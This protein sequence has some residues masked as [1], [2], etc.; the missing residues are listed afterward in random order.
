MNEKKEKEEL[1]KRLRRERIE[2]Q[3]Q[4]NQQRKKRVEKKSSWIDNLDEVGKV[5]KR[6]PRKCT[7]ELN[8]RL[9]R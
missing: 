1:E 7:K 5:Y 2:R 9:S 8:L 4:A 3:L 6:S